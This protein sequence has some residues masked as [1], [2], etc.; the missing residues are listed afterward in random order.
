MRVTFIVVAIA[1]CVAPVM[2]TNAEDEKVVDLAECIGLGFASD[3]GLRM[4]ELDSQIAD[5][6][7]HEMQDQYLPSLSLQGGYSRLSEVPVG[8]I[9]VNLPK[10]IGSQTIPFPPALD[11]ST[12]FGLVLQQPLFTGQRIASSVKQA[13]A[14]QD[15]SRADVAENRSQLRYRITEA[16]W[17]FAKSKVQVQD[18]AQSV[19]QAESHLDDAQK[20]FAQGMATTNDML[21]AR[22]RLEDAQIQL[23]S[24]ESAREIARVQLEILI[25]VPWNAGIDIPDTKSLDVEP[26]KE[27][28]QELVTR[29]LASR[30]DI[31]AARSQ[32]IAQEASVVSTRA[33]LF[34]TVFLTGDYTLAN[35]NQ[36]V[37]PQTNQFL[38]SWSVGL[39]ASVDV[40]RY[41][42]VL[43]QEEQAKGKLTQT[44]ENSRK[45]TDAVTSDVVSAYLTLN[46]AIVQL[47]SLHQ[48]TTQAEENDRVTQER[49][50]EG[51]IKSSESLDAQTLL[52]QARLRENN[53]FYNCRVAQAALEM[54]IGD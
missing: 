40:G 53:A 27:N 28:L 18:F 30:P 52:V 32:E 47:A 29:A 24:S 42:Q 13:Q 19:A 50:R 33:G 25:G 9:S 44:R 5:A 38:G 23:T 43:A 51:V 39:M 1:L 41:P 49:Y 8:S 45:V 6:R 21:Q 7:L 16:Y 46:Q 14:L 20:L 37:F 11:N 36:R 34:P 3:A 4:A 54:A 10:P 48:E 35:P 15:S 17:N 26:P 31:Q 22:M 12:S 2:R